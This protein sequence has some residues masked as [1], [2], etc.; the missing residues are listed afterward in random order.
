MNVRKQGTAYVLIPKIGDE[1]LTSLMGFAKEENIAAGSIQAIGALQDFELGY[2]YLNKKEYGRKK[3]NEIAELISCSGNLASREGNPFIHIH[4][5]MGR[6]DFS[7]I[8]GHLFS[9]IVAVTAEVILFPFPEK[10][11]R[12]YDERT[13]LFLL[14]CK[15]R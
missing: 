11:D 15:E 13:G 7:V 4:V 8:G 14:N 6:D 1:L 9:G 2:Y 10:M 5:A 3:F 12:T